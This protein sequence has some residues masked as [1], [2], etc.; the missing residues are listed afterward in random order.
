M[1]QSSGKCDKKCSGS[2]SKVKLEGDSGNIYTFNMKV[3]SG[4]VSFSGASVELAAVPTEAPPAP[5]PSAGPAC[6]CIDA[7]KIG[8]MPGSGSSMPGSGSGSVAGGPVELQLRR[9]PKSSYPLAVCNDGTQATYYTQGG[10]HSGKVMIWLQGGGA[11]WDKASC[12]A[13]CEAGSEERE[14]CTSQ[15]EQEI[16]FRE[17]STDKNP[18][19]DYWMVYVHYCSSDLWS[20]TNAASSSTWGYNFQGKNIVDSI[21]QDLSDNHNLLTATKVVLTGCSAGTA[22]VSFNCDDLAA[23]MPNADFRCVADAPDFFPPTQALHQAALPG[24]QSSRTRQHSCGAGSMTS[25]ARTTQTQTMWTTWGSC[26]VL[27]PVVYSSYQHLSY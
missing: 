7:S 19:G 12:D 18:Y 9:L 24:T 27:W 2:A 11:C 4:K 10:G 21:I 13:R 20:G 3:K 6:S 25:L 26:A 1:K 14:L 22:G 23:K 5:T 15:T 16:S 8:G 17:G